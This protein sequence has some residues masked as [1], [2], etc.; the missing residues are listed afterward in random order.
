MH[1]AQVSEEEV[2]AGVNLTPGMRFVLEYIKDMDAGRYNDVPAG[3][4]YHKAAIFHN[5]NGVDYTGSDQIWNW[6]SQI[7]GQFSKFRHDVHFLTDTEQDDGNSYVTCRATRNIWIPGDSEHSPSV[8]APLV[9]CTRVGKGDCPEAFLGLQH[10][11]TWLYWDTM[12]LAPFMNKD[13]IVF[14]KRNVALEE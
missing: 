6:I 11:E 10:R 3:K 12:L 2:K 1:L 5:T 9:I 13:A 8:K 7:F 14:Q 4:F